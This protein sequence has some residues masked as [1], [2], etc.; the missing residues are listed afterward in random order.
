VILPQFL[1]VDKVAPSVVGWSVAV[2]IS[3]GEE[4]IKYAPT[5]QL[6]HAGR[7]VYDAA[8]LARGCSIVCARGERLRHSCRA[9]VLQRAKVRMIDQ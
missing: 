7:F 5:V 1:G 9:A 6:H 3:G 2:K 4:S 8:T